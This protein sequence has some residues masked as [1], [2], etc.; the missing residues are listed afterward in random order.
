MT[1]ETSTPPK[2]GSTLLI[3]L[4]KGSVTLYKKFPIKFIRLLVVLTILKAIID[5]FEFL[6]EKKGLEDQT[7][8]VHV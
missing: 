8:I 2:S 7:Q 4:S 5:N 1:G 6:L 3:G